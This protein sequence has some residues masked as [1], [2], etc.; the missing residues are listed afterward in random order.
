MAKESIKVGHVLR[1]ILISL[2]LNV[3]VQLDSFSESK[4]VL[5]WC[6]GLGCMRCKYSTTSDPSVAGSSVSR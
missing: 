1:K 5:I 3:Y 2:A 6:N 4:K